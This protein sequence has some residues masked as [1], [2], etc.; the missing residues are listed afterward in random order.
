M[1]TTELLK[2]ASALEKKA[3]A[4]FVSSFTKAGIVSLVQ[5]GMPFEKAAETMKQACEAN[6]TL[7]GHQANISAF[8]KAAE[9]I[10]H[11]EARVGELEKVAE[12]A[13]LE[14]QKH[15]DTNPLSKLAAAGFTEEEIALMSQMPNQL[16]EK[17]ATANSQPWEM[18]NAVGVAREKTDPFL[19]WILN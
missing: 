5:G 2:Q 19:E 11:L 8:E 6:A 16:I 7:I 1:N 4:D 9:Y 18:G 15:D 10:E 3:Y 17:V 14:V 12:Q 13:E